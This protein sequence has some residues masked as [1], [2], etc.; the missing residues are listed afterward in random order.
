MNRQATI[1]KMVLQYYPDA[2]AIY[3]FG[4]FGTE[5]EWPSSDVDVAVLLSPEE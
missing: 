4:S 2:Q 5:D 1:T 3:L